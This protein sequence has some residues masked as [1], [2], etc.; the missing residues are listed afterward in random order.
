MK[1]WEIIADNLSKGGWRWGCVS[2]ID[3]NGRTILVADAYRARKSPLTSRISRTNCRSGCLTARWGEIYNSQERLNSQ[4]QQ[5][6]QPR[7]L[8]P[9]EN[10]KDTTNRHARR[11]F[12]RHRKR[13]LR[14]ERCALHRRPGLEHHHGQS[15]VRHGRRI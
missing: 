3:C 4:L 13:V 12:A 9:N 2:A 15:Q 1:Y 8:A 7:K 10:H 6:P 14:T 11:A 5:R